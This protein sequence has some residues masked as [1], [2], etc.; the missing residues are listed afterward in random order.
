MG[1]PRTHLCDVAGMAYDRRLLD[2]A[3]GNFSLRV[4]ERI[5]CT[6]RYSGSRR[7]W[8]LRPEEILEL[9]LDGERLHGEG[10]LSREVR[11]HVGIYRAFP[12][13]G[14]VCHA[15]PLNLLVFAS[16][17][18]PLPPTSEQTE[19]YGTIE[20]AQEC[21]AHSEELARTVVET[22]ARKQDR[23]AKHAIACLLPNHGITVAGRDLDDAYDALERLDGSAYIL[24]ARAALEAQR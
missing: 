7:R 24:I 20:L 4:G 3:G 17:R 19:K 23:L 2:S 16:L 1:D 14:G 8:Q 9:S 12:E 10:E 13:A 5:F 22:L 18:R 11:M 21:P 6:P 15:H